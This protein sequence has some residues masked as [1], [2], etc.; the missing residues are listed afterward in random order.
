M[1]Y[2]N[3]N[4]TPTQ[5]GGTDISYIYKAGSK[6]I[7]KACG[8]ICSRFS[9]SQT[10]DTWTEKSSASTPARQVLESREDNKT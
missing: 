5:D 3:F 1:L 8:K 10:Q 6:E 9:Q 4:K 2:Q 7:R